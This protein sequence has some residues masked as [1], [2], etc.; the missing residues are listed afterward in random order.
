MV[1]V[2]R[3]SALQMYIQLS[4]WFIERVRSFVHYYRIKSMPE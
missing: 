1:I 4:H 3:Y 2:L